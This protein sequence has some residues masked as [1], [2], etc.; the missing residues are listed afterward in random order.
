MEASD[1]HRP[2]TSSGHLGCGLRLAWVPCLL[3]PL[4]CPLALVDKLLLNFSKLPLLNPGDNNYPVGL[5]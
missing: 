5:L 3:L 1:P 4:I 2:L